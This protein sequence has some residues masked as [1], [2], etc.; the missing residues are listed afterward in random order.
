MR[1]RLVAALLSFSVATV[2]LGASEPDSTRSEYLVTTSAGFLLEP[3]GGAHYGLSFSVVKPQG[4][5][6]Y[7]IAEFENPEEASKPFATEIVLQA[8][9]RTFRVQSPGI[10][11]IQNN[12]R[13]GV[14]LKLYSDAACK[15]QLGTHHQEVLFSVPRRMKSAIAG[16]AALEI[17]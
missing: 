6:I 1:T 9:A 7:V 5:R 3:G 11:V 14:T 4:S 10:R 2:A 8:D 17:H 16:Q 13:Y 15:N 12:R